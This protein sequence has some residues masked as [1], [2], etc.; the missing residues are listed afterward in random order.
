MPPAPDRLTGS[1]IDGR[2]RVIR[3]VGRGGAGIVYEALHEAMARRV[4][5][6]VLGTSLGDGEPG[7]RPL[8]PRGAR[9]RTAE[10][11]ARRHR[12]R[13]RRHRRRAPVPGHGVLRGRQPRRPAARA[14]TL[15]LSD[16]VGLMAGVCAAM[17]AAHAAGIV[18]RDLK[19][20]NI[21]F[22]QGV[23]KVADFGLAHLMEE[24]DHTL[25]AGHI[26]GSPH[27]MSPEQWQ[28]IPADGRS[29][30]YSL[31]VIAYEA[32]T[33]AHPFKGTST[34]AVLAAHLTGAPTP[35][36]ELRPDLPEDAAKA[37]LKAI[38]RE[39]DDRFTRPGA[40]A[41]ALASA[42]PTEPGC[43]LGHP[44]GDRAAGGRRAHGPGDRRVAVARDP[45]GAHRGD[46]RAARAPRGRAA[47]PGRADHDRGRARHGQEHAAARRSWSAR[48]CWCPASWPASGARPST[49]ARPR[50]TSPFLEA[51]GSLARPRARGTRTGRCGRLAPTWAVP[52]A[53]RAGRRRR[54]RGGA[55]RPR[56]HAARAAGRAVGAGRGAHAS[57]WRSRTC[58]GPTPSASTCC[59]SWR[60]A[61]TTAAS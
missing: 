13:L 10:P 24:E 9:G 11:P 32:L 50:R 1:L 41:E 4:A 51:L 5:I 8:P 19:P 56:P 12:P 16:T 22:A 29:D 2:Y 15:P 25:T 48:A 43:A 18:H 21:L 20:A 26:I 31:G 53:V 30:V 14:R 52:P 17:D 39:P 7:D 33:G 34:R 6:K 44:R 60:R 49:S 27:Y 35:P 42:L 55:A 40:F 38:A 57:C 23:V 37:I 58:T 28:S 3:Q 59:T 36:G 45:A 46:G 61:S 47:G 54:R